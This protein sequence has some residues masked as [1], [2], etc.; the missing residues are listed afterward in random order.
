MPPGM[1]PYISSR[2]L[3]Y[4]P[5]SYLIMTGLS[6]FP[7]L[8]DQRIYLGSR[9]ADRQQAGVGFNAFAEY[10]VVLNVFWGLENQGLATLK[11]SRVG[12]SLEPSIADP[13]VLMSILWRAWL[14]KTA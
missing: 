13:D 10:F 14:W 8:E 12:T 1:G 11:L 4:G 6:G 5:L 2:D 3:K 9:T 7:V